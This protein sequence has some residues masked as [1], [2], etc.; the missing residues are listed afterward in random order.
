[1][2]VEII[3]NKPVI[4]KDNLHNIH[5]LPQLL[6]ETSEF[7]NAYVYSPFVIPNGITV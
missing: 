6:F 2:A 3:T 1:M 5:F 7:R 4:V